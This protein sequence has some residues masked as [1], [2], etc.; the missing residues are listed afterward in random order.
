MKLLFLILALTLTGCAPKH[1]KPTPPPFTE[2]WN[3]WATAANARAKEPGTVN[4]NE[5]ELWPA[6]REGIEKFVR[7][8]DAFYGSTTR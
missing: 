6:V 7:D 5:R 3:A 2:S 8:M 4:V 1:V